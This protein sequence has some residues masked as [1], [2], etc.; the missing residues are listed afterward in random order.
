[1]IKRPIS[2]DTAL[3]CVLGNPIAHSLSPAMH[4][5]AFAH[6]QLNAVYLAFPVTD[7]KA[8]LTGI[9]A[10]DI[11]G[12]SITLPHKT[13]VMEYLD[14]I[15][16]EAVNIGAVNTLINDNGRLIGRNSD[17]TGAIDALHGQTAIED[18]EVLIFGAGG[19]ARAIGFGIRGSGGNVT[20]T[21]RSAEAGEKLAA[22]LGGAFLPAR[23]L[24]G[25]R[26]DILINT[27]PVGMHP[28]INASPVPFE[29]LAPEM[30]VMD[31]VYNPLETRFLKEASRA[32]CK[33]VDGLAMF[34]NQGAR[35]FEWW[36]GEK[37][38]VEVMRQAAIDCLG[39]FTACGK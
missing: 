14:E 10:L 17:I 15:D 3:Y 30:V 33:T 8:A 19:A 39:N 12:A 37:A 28:A 34:V 11:K 5:R 2:T 31:I 35:Q 27:T 26:F 6:S 18:K 22:N 25:G 20:I 1:M 38:P 9:R 21:N 32:G 16:K 4:N 23:E 13:P 29:I 7:I 36:T 24:P